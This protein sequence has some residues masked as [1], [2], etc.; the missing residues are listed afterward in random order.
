MNFE[1]GLNLALDK[2]SSWTSSLIAMLPNLLVASVILV[3]GLYLAKR[4]RKFADKKLRKFFPTVTL[5]NLTI[6]LIYIFFV[7]VVIFIVLKVLNLDSTLSTALG[8]A[9]ILSVGLAFAFQDIAANFISGIFL[10]FSKPFKVGELIAVNKYEGF[11]EGVKLRDTTLR[12]HQGYLVTV[13]NKQIFQ[14]PLINYTRYG[15]RRAD[16]TSGVSQGDDLK[17]VRAVA[18]E[19]LQKVPNVIAEDTTFYFEGLGESTI[20]FKI[21]IWVNSDQYADYLRFINDVI[22]ILKEAFDA[23]DISLP[24]PIRTIDFNMKGGEKLSDM[25]LQIVNKNSEAT[26]N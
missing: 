21:R 26:Q 11:V 13:P 4:I 18:T 2:I 5:A 14:S 20:D 16:I 1:K 10:S 15:K 9:G 6:S 7:G 24:F 25:K 3:V 22:I 23:N 12:T 17:K 8:F 19:A